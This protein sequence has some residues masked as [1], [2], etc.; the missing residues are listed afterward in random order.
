MFLWNVHYTTC[1]VYVISL[2]KTIPMVVWLLRHR[3]ITQVI[4]YIC[5]FTLSSVHVHEF[6]L[7]NDVCILTQ[8]HTYV[9]IVP[10]LPSTSSGC[11][12]PS[13]SSS[14]RLHL[15]SDDNDSGNEALPY[16][17]VHRF[18]K[19]FLLTVKWKDNDY[20]CVST[21]SHARTHACTHTHTNTQTHTEGK[22]LQDLLLQHLSVQ[23]YN[24]L[25]QISA[26]SDFEDLSL[27][28]KY[29]CMDKIV[30]V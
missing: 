12:S 25:M 19:L 1:T 3:Q 10:S 18:Q 2:Q 26:T 13:S 29:V 7:S 14:S 8:L 22:E 30:A 16:S 23:E 15:N 11:N 4:H 9:Y 24:Y 20:T 6:P 21:D 5:L 27:F 28:A 17:W